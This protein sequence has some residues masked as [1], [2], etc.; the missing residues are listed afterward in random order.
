MRIIIFLL[1][2][3]FS[4]NAQ[5]VKLDKQLRA[6][7]ENPD[8]TI[9]PN[10]YINYERII[11]LNGALKNLLFSKAEEYFV[12]KYTNGNG[13]IQINDRETGRLV[14]KATFGTMAQS[15]G[16][17]IATV[18]VIYILKVEVKDGKARITVSLT[19]YVEDTIAWGGDAYYDDVYLMTSLYPFKDRGN[20]KGAYGKALLAA[21]EAVQVL[22]D[23]VEES[24]RK[25]TKDW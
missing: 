18:D 14:G 24:L 2:V 21:R 25:E 16:L 13:I 20:N 15:V 9:D 8:W 19:H 1:F 5:S 4:G 17:W 11:D 12:Y 10:G 22:M 7:L 3:C 23:Q 6:L